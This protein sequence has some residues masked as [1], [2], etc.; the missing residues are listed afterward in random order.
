MQLWEHNVAVCLM[1][2]DT[3]AIA[4]AEQH[5]W[6]LCGVA[7][8]LLQAQSGGVLVAQQP[9]MGLK[10]YFKREKQEHQAGTEKRNG[11]LSTLG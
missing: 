8:C 6:Q 11:V 10:L 4:D 1:D 3:L 9:Q 2:A 5:G 7:P